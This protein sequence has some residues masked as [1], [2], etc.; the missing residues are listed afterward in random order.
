MYVRDPTARPCT[1]ACS[2]VPAAAVTFHICPK[3]PYRVPDDVVVHL[4]GAVDADDTEHHKDHGACIHQRPHCR[5][6]TARVHTGVEA[7]GGRDAGLGH[8]RKEGSQRQ[9]RGWAQASEAPLDTPR[10]PGCA[11]ST[12]VTRHIEEAFGGPVRAGAEQASRWRHTQAPVEGGLVRLSEVQLP[13]EA[14]R[15]G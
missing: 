7:K 5:L 11:P 14:G 12:S 10:L 4:L 6:P 15:P 1:S 8:C 3:W 13:V 9:R 2:Q